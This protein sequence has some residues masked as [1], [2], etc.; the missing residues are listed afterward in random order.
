VCYCVLCP[1]LIFCFPSIS[2]ESPLVFTRFRITVYPAPAFFGPSPAPSPFS[3]LLSAQHCMVLSPFKITR[4]F[5]FSRFIIFAINALKILDTHYRYIIKAMY[6]EKPKRFIIWNGGSTMQKGL[7]SL[8]IDK[9]LI[10]S[11]K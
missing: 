8:Q 9:C 10:C 3:S 2:V 11:H 6:L 1:G 7:N 5:G 4:H